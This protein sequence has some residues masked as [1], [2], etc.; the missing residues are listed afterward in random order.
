MY[1]DLQKM[2]I[3]SHG[4]CACVPHVALAATDACI[5]R[6]GLILLAGLNQRSC[7]ATSPTGAFRHHSGDG[8]ERLQESDAPGTVAE[9]RDLEQRA[10]TASNP[11]DPALPLRWRP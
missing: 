7:A 9:L 11:L 1:S 5:V 3:D 6:S 10:S 8:P 4:P 2:R